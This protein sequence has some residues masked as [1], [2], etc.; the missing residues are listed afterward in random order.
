MRDRQQEHKEIKN[1]YNLAILGRKIKDL[2]MF[3]HFTAFQIQQ[4]NDNNAQYRDPI[5]KFL[6]KT[7]H[8]SNHNTSHLF[9]NHLHA[10]LS[11]NLLKNANSFNNTQQTQRYNKIVYPL[12]VLNFEENLNRNQESTQIDS[13]QYNKIDETIK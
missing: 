5:N 4:N 2:D 8:S 13:K 11:R 10:I 7:K 6:R 9:N 1:F 12:T 3:I